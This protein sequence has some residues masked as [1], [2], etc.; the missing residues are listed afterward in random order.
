MKKTFVLACISVL[1]LG[2]MSSRTCDDESEALVTKVLQSFTFRDTGF[3]TSS[4]FFFYTA[5]SY[6][7]NNGNITASDRGLRITANPF[8]ATQ[9]QSAG[10]SL[11]QIKFLAYMAGSINAT[12][13]Y[14]EVACEG[15]FSGRTFGTHK[16]PFGAQ[17]AD[18]ETDIRL[19][20]ADVNVLDFDSLISVDFAFTN[21]KLYA[22]YE[23]LV[24]ARTADN[25]YA[26]FSYAIPLI[27]RVP[28]QL[29]D[30]KIAYNKTAG[31]IRWVIDGA[32]VFRV[33]RIGFRISREFMLFDLGGQEQ[34]VSPDAIN[35]GLGLFTIL[36]AYPPCSNLTTLSSGAQVCSFPADEKAL[37]RLSTQQYYNPRFGYPVN[38]TFVDNE[39]EE[40]SRL[41]GQG[42]SLH[43]I[44]YRQTITV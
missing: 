24:S 36:D 44:F 35:C 11:D 3:N 15:R 32:E 12:E 33:N 27:S 43:S 18:P 23:R 9:P 29:H 8:T 14:S 5:G 26:A 2:V 28:N 39:S 13:P 34:I 17:V 22:I 37:V 4:D 30:L 10:G 6:V 31:T 38:A 7:A 1:V 19:A 41:F 20:I 25:F 40:S 16:Q 42:A 21:E